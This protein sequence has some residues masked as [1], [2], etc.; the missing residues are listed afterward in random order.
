MLSRALAVRAVPP[1]QSD[2]PPGAVTQLK[3]TPHMRYF[4]SL[5]AFVSLVS[6]AL[7]L[8]DNVYWP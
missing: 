1:A 5:A 6:S 8:A 7:F 4:A 2:T 3:E